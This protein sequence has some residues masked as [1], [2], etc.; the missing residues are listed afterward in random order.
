MLQLLVI[1]KVSRSLA[2]LHENFL[3]DL[4]DLAEKCETRLFFSQIFANFAD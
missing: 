4:A 2:E 1:W 3:A